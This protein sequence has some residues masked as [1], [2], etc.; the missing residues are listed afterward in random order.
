[1][2]HKLD[3]AGA[4]NRAM[5]PVAM[6]AAM[7]IFIYANATEKE[8]EMES[9]S[10]HSG[11][12][13]I[14]NAAQAGETPLEGK[15]QDHRRQGRRCGY[16][17]GCGSDPRRTPWDQRPLRPSRSPGAVMQRVLYRI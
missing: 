6:P 1:V 11:G 3:T 4:N 8:M 7:S 9:F 12:G 15:C 14:S 5:Q 16:G 17:P 10:S 2:P 13:V